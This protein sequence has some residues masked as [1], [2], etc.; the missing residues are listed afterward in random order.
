MLSEEASFGELK[1]HDVAESA[2]ITIHSYYIHELQTGLDELQ[3]HTRFNKILA[4]ILLADIRSLLSHSDLGQKSPVLF[5][6]LKWRN[7]AQAV[8]LIRGYKEVSDVYTVDMS[9]SN[10]ENKADP[11]FVR[12]HIRCKQEEGSWEFCQPTLFS[13]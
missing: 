8:A 5:Y 13:M 1:S 4:L 6:Y 12:M 9:S 10:G 3:L 11:N 2:Y 7:K